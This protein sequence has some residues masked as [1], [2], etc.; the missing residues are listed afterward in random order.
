VIT[1]VLTWLA[2][3]VIFTAAFCRSIHLAKVASG[4]VFQA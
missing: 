1:F 4:E 2:L 3:S